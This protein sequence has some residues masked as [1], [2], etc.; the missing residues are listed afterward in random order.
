[1]NLTY[2]KS[3]CHKFLGIAW[4]CSVQSQ[5]SK[6]SPNLLA[7]P[8]GQLISS[9][10]PASLQKPLPFWH[11]GDAHILLLASQF[12]QLCF[13][14]LYPVSTLQALLGPSALWLP[15]WDLLTP[16]SSMKSKAEYFLVRWGRVSHSQCCHLCC[17]SYNG[18][19]NCR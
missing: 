6:S 4:E 1:M 2:I 17:L 11:D 19:K 10:I 3:H 15:S 8:T 18:I 16:T 13:L 5:N 9:A 12:I 7:C 14:S